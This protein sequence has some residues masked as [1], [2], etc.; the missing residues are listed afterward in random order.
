MEIYPQAAE[1]QGERENNL[2]LSDD[3]GI[4]RMTLG[5]G[6]DTPLGLKNIC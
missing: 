2:C 4:R 6:H 3:P 5:K 1:L